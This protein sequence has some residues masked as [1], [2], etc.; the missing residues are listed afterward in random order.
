M[1]NSDDR[2]NQYRRK[3]GTVESRDDVMRVE[4]NVP[5]KYKDQLREMADE[6]EYAEWH[7]SARIR[8]N[9]PVAEM[10]WQD[11]LK[12]DMDEPEDD[13]NE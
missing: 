7:Y 6:T 2:L 8:H 3:R 13:Q 1:S 9:S 11:Y 4:M 10:I 5:R 12:P